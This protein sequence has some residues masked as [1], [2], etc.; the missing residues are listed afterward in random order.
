MLRYFFV[1]LVLF[2]VLLFAQPQD[3]LWTRIFDVSPNNSNP[4]YA[5]SL[6][7]NGNIAM[8]MQINDTSMFGGITML[9]GAGEIEWIKA[10]GFHCYD[11]SGF[12]TAIISERI[13]GGLMV[14]GTTCPWAMWH[15]GVTWLRTT[16][17]GDSLDSHTYFYNLFYRS[18]QVEKAISLANGDY[19]AI[20]WMIDQLSPPYSYYSSLMAFDSVGNLMGMDSSNVSAEFSFKDAIALDDGN[21]LV[22]SISDSNRQLKIEKINPLNFD[23][24][25]SRLIDGFIPEASVSICKDPEGGYAVFV[26]KYDAPLIIKIDNEGNVIWSHA[27]SASYSN[28][29]PIPTGG[30]VALSGDALVRLDGWGNVLWSHAFAMGQQSYESYHAVT[31]MPDSSYVLA[32]VSHTYGTFYDKTIIL[33]TLPDTTA[34]A[35]INEPRANMP[36]SFELSAY[37]NPFNPESK[38]RFS[39]AQNEQLELKVYDMQGRFVT[40][41]AQG[42]F[43]QGTHE[44]LFDARA[45]PSSVYIYRLESNS[46]TVSKKMILLK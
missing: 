29:I 35:A 6:M 38:I 10:Y 33:R 27:L 16:A 30:Y 40:T 15:G 1:I 11:G 41:L 7:H 25:W 19:L 44:V 23:R 28:I 32:G 43:T 36:L 3:T 8:G 14:F 34:I 13:D 26:L 24:Y 9:N 45:L 4:P 31:I 21:C 17:E 2:P 12:Q 46:T 39:L 37:P 42:M 20:C 5:L 22:V 18:S